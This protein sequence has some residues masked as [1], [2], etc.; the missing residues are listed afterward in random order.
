[1]NPY[2]NQAE[3]NCRISGVQAGCPVIAEVLS[4]VLILASP[5]EAMAMATVFRLKR[6]YIMGRD[7]NN[8]P[9]KDFYYES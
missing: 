3:D 1:V 7:K 5:V 4:T 2:T 6:A 8:Q 9:V